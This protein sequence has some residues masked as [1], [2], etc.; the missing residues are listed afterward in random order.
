MSDKRNR[1]NTA[2]VL[3]RTSCHTLHG[4]SGTLLLRGSGPVSRSKTVPV[5]PFTKPSAWKGGCS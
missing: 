5:L 3:P 2:S 1:N 4:K